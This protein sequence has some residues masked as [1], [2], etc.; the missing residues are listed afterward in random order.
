VSRSGGGGGE[1]GEGEWGEREIPGV[2]DVVNLEQ[3]SLLGVFFFFEI[4]FFGLGDIHSWSSR[5]RHR[6]F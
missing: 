6:Q 4:F 5:R 3:L 1:G 2:H